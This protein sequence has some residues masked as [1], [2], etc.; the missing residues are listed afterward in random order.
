MS[1]VLD[2]K[3]FGYDATT[4]KAAFGD[5][6]TRFNR[7]PRAFG[8]E[9]APSDSYPYSRRMGVWQRVIAKPYDKYTK[10]MMHFDESAVKDEIGN[11]WTAANGAELSTAEKKF[12]A[13]SLRMQSSGTMYLELG[14]ADVPS[15]DT[16][17]FTGDVWFRMT[18][19]SQNA[20]YLFVFWGFPEDGSQRT[21]SVA[22]RSNYIN[23]EF[24]GANG[25][26]SYNFSL[27]TWYHLAMVR[28]GTT[29]MIFVNGTLVKT[30]SGVPSSI[31]CSSFLIS[32]NM[33]GNS[34]IGYLDEFRFSVGI[35]RWTSNF[36]PPTQP[37]E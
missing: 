25:T 11:T 22:I 1:D 6:Q 15:I 5:G 33:A 28:S 26:I 7:L 35:A 20:A 4:R 29:G 19:W 10:V 30:V 16:E 34:Y 13:S 24:A 9:H 23:Y 14:S 17:D 3:Q 21:T 37:Y 18:E 27:N 12:G 36:T 2:N 32:S 8:I 31:P